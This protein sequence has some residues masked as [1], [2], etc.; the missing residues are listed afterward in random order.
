MIVSNVAL[1]NTE[2]L[3]LSEHLEHHM[4]CLRT[5]KNLKMRS[6]ECKTRGFS[7]VHVFWYFG[8]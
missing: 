5:I 7:K 1:H 8:T 3:C 4:S 6:L 2:K